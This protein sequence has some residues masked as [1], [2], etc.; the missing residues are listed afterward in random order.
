MRRAKGNGLTADNSQPAKR[1]TKYATD[2]IATCARCASW[3]A[4]I[5]CTAALVAAELV[6]LVVNG[7]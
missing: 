6:R 4:V 5:A 2:F 7:A 3:D 1:L